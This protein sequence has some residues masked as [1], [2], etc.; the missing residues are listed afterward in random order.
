MSVAKRGRALAERRYF[1]AFRGDLTA[2]DRAALHRAGFKIYEGGRGVA[3]SAWAGDEDM[4]EM[5]RHQVV[6]VVADTEEDARQ[7]V[8][9]ALARV[10]EGITVDWAGTGQPSLPPPIPGD[11]LPGEAPAGRS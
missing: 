2:R 6:R 4:F 3:S 10:P 5:H 1:I 11:D 8:I 9:R 7:Q